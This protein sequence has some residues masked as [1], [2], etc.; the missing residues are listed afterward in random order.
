MSIFL[1]IGAPKCGSTTIQ[2]Q[3]SKNKDIL[4][5]AGLV[6]PAEQIDAHRIGHRFTTGWLKNITGPLTTDERALLARDRGGDLLMS[7]EVCLQIAKEPHQLDAFIA[8]FD[9]EEPLHLLTIIRRP[10]SQLESTWLQWMRTYRTFPKVAEQMALRGLH[11][12]AYIRDGSWLSGLITNW[13]RWK[14]HDRVTSIETLYME[15]GPR[16]DFT[17]VLPDFTKRKMVLP[18]STDDLNISMNGVSFRLLR[19]FTQ[20]KIPNYNRFTRRIEALTNQAGFSKFRIL[21][22]SQRLEIDRAMTNVELFSPYSEPPEN[23]PSA[24]ELDAATWSDLLQAAWAI[25]DEETKSA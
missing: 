25:A 9:P 15:R 13:S 21:T 8:C 16:I 24:Y 10:S 14:A 3:L 4:K 19:E 18:S 1:H 11:I 22:Y 12:D 17:Q 2:S 20:T 7:S 23:K 6:T 5:Q